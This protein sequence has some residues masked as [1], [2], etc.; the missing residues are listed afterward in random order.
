MSDAAHDPENFCYR[1]PDRQSY[2]LCQRCGR[3]VCPECSTQA[4]V[5]V[6]CPECVKE[7]RQSAPKRKPRLL[8]SFRQSSG[9]PVVT[10]SLIGINVVVLALQY[11]SSGFIFQA[12][13]LAPFLAP[14]EP[15]RLVTSM[16]LHSQTSIFHILFNMYSLFIFG[17]MI[18]HLVGR[19]RFLVLYLLAGIGG[20]VLVVAIGDPYIGVIG[21]SGAIFGLLGAYFVIARRS[22]ANTTQLVIVIALNLGIGF[23][24][25]NIAWQAHVGGLL[26]GGAVALIYSRTTRAGQGPLQI[27]MLVGVTAVLV[28]VTVVASILRHFV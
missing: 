25:P 10:Y 3:T 17:P 15:W 11:V 2:I 6:H 19:L 20:S 8:T 9:T 4:A 27:G 21:A 16:F 5:G 7:A 14:T 26:I 18:E 1:H 22:G 12:F 13:A 23:L 24:V 28:A